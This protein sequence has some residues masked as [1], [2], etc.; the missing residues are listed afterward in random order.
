MPTPEE[1]TAAFNDLTTVGAVEKPV[2]ISQILINTPTPNPIAGKNGQATV[3]FTHI[4][5][6]AD[7]LAWSPAIGS[8]VI[9]AD[10]V[11]GRGL[12]AITADQI[13]ALVAL[14]GPATLDQRAGIAAVALLAFLK[15]QFA[16]LGI[17]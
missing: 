14:C 4:M 1:I 6:D 11:Y 12:A 9:T 2:W 3:T 8:T 13:A 15:A 5:R 7:G 10:N 17:S 16:D